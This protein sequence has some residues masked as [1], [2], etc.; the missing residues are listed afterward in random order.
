MKKYLDAKRKARKAVHQVNCE[1][2][3]KKFVLVWGK[4]RNQD[5]IGKQ[6]VRNDNGVLVVCN[7]GK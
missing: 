6:C 3:E 7:E 2:E 1:A 5:V 4:I